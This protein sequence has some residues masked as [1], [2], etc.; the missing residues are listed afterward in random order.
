M[1]VA[2]WFGEGSLGRSMGI[3]GVVGAQNLCLGHMVFVCGSSFGLAGGIFPSSFGMKWVME[4][5]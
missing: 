1:V 3:S 5:V 4:L 2:L